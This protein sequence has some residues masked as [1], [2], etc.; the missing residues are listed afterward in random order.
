[1]VSPRDTIAAN[2]S[3]LE[4]FRQS[5]DYDYTRELVPDHD[6]N[7]FDRFWDALEDFFD[8]SDP[9]MDIPTWLWWFLGAIV[10][11]SVGYLIW[12]NWAGLFGPGDVDLTEQDITENDINEVDFDQLIAEAERNGDYLMLCRLRY[13]QTLKAASDVS[14]VAWRRY[15]TPTQYAQEWPDGDIARMTNH[16]LRIRY[17]HYT[18]S[19]ALADEMRSLQEVLQARIVADGRQ[20]RADNQQ[21][22]DSP[23]ADGQQKGGE[24][25]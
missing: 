4:A 9:Q 17:G 24:Q 7:Y 8:F 22:A 13:L 2:D 16:F 15:K 10:L 25:P 14:L 19:A 12:K 18:V 5:R 6:V 1:M 20:S 3:V 11:A 21:Q 23:Q